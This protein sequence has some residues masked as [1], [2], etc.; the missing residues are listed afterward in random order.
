LSAAAAG[1][2]VTR[3]TR[4]LHVVVGVLLALLVVYLVAVAGL[5]LYA[6]R[7]PD[8]VSA[9]DAVRLLPDVVRL[10]R[11]LA[12]DRS[13]PRGARIRLVLL[14]VYLASPIDLIPDFIPVV[15]YADDAVVIGLVLRSVVRVS[16][17]AALAKHWPGSPS[18]LALV[19]RLAG[20]PAE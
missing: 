7:H 9:R 17:S 16:G 14:L 19:Q 10:I 4:V 20:L 5:W 6:R 13:L 12:A 8:M 2:A 1:A 3:V 11:R 15:G 18:G